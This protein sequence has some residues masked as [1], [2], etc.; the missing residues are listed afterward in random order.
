MLEQN[1]RWLVFRK[2]PNTMMFRTMFKVSSVTVVFVC[3]QALR[4]VI[5]A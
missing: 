3:M 2:S 1:Y 5:A 4:L